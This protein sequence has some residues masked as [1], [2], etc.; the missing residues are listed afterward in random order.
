MWTG[1][2]KEEPEGTLHGGDGMSPPTA[3]FVL[4][5]L[6]RGAKLFGGR[7]GYESGISSEYLSG[8]PSIAATTTTTTGLTLI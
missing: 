3:C 5:T 1:Y 4:P 7:M 2:K 8:I 6:D